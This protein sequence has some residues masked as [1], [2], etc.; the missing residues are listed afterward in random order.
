MN[1]AKWCNTCNETQSHAYDSRSDFDS[2]GR[3]TKSQ[4]AYVHAPFYSLD[5]FSFLN[6]RRSLL[7]VAHHGPPKTA[8][9]RP[10]IGV[11]PGQLG[12]SFARWVRASATVFSV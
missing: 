9:D 3:K 4:D 1:A 7:K 6:L 10:S 2:L 11:K 12:Q 5:V 8:T